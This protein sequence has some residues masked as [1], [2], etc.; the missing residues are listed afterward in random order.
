MKFVCTECGKVIDEEDIVYVEESRGEFWGSPCSE[1]MTYS[2]CCE[3]P[4]DDYYPCCEYCRYFAGINDSATGETE[5]GCSLKGEEVDKSD[6]CKEY[7]LS[8]DKTYA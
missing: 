3:V 6:L 4:L 2:P 1:T 7:E 8:E 5:Y